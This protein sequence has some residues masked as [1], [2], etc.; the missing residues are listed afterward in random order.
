M[1]GYRGKL[2]RYIQMKGVTY[3]FKMALPKE[4]IPYF[5]GKKSI[6]QSLKTGDRKTARDRRDKLERDL[7][8]IFKAYRDGTENAP[9]VDIALN[10][11]AGLSRS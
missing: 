11:G 6:L 7:K 4:M 2:D 5:D 9:K 10:L 3:W 1:A 8:D